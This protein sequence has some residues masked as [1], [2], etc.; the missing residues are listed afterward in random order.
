MGRRTEAAGFDLLEELV[1]ARYRS[2]AEKQKLLSNASQ[3]LDRL[4]LLICMAFDLRSL[5]PARYE[6]LSRMEREIGRMLGGRQK[7]GAATG[8]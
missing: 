8:T 4:R 3:A 5:S 1:A 2:S 7:R 6:E